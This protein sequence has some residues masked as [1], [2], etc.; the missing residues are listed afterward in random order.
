MH[1]DYQIQRCVHGHHSQF[2][3]ACVFDPWFDPLA[4]HRLDVGRH[5]LFTVPL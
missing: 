5:V 3:R 1:F 4:S 2:L